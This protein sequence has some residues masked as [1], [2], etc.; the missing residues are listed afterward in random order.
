MRDAL[1][2]VGEGA[3][4]SGGRAA[5]FDGAFGGFQ[6]VLE[7][8][9]GNLHAQVAAMVAVEGEIGLDRGGC[10]PGV[11]VE[12]ILASGWRASS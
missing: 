4:E 11:E 3:E 6:N 5:A 12:E 1:E 8:V 10:G 9:E 2:S 7:S